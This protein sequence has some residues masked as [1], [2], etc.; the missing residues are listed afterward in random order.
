M[1][2]LPF[3]AAALFAGAAIAQQPPQVG[4]IAPPTPP[5]A[6]PQDVPYP[7]VMRLQVDATDIDRRIFRARQTI[8]VSRAG[9]MTLLYPKW[10]P[11]K[12]GP[13]GAPDKLGGLV[14][15]AHGRPVPWRRDPVESWAYH[16]DVPAGARALD[17]EF[18]F[19]TPT[20]P[21]QGRINV[22][23]E[24][25]NLQWEMVVFYP[26][27]HYASR[28][29][30]QPTLT[31]PQGWGYGAALDPA[32]SSGATT[33]FQPVTLEQL[34]DSPLFAGRHFRQVELDGGALPVRLNI[35]A[36]APENLAIKPE[37]VQLHRNLVIQADR[38][39]GARHFTEYDFLLALTDR[40][41][42]I[43]LE[44]HESSE[45]AVDPNYF[46]EWDKHLGDH[47]LLPHEYVHSWNG[48]FRRGADMWAPNYDVPTRNQFLWVYEGMT[49][50]WGQVLA[51][52]SGLWTRENA[53]GMMAMTAAAYQNRAGR[54]WRALVDTTNDPIILA[55][56][57]QA[58]GNW[59]R[60]E[61]YYNEGLLI[62]LE[63][64]TLIRERS[65][66]RRS[67]DDFARRFFG[68]DSGRA[69][70]KTYDFDEI[71]ATLNA[72]QAY[73]WATFLRTR[74]ENAGGPAPLE[75]FT[76]GGYRL[77]Y[78]E[79]P[80][81]YEKS[82]A[83]GNVSLLYSLGLALNKDAKI[84]SVMW[85]GPA[86]AAGLAVGPTLVAV[87]GLAYTSDRLTKAITAAKGGNQPIELLVKDGDRYRTVPIRYHG[88]LRYPHLERVDGTPGRLDDILKPR[89]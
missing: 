30:V 85:E 70:V 44:H 22:T 18:Q 51:A 3:L 11:G 50:Y 37:Q 88:G 78:R 42:G 84:T 77:V 19:L 1:K 62:W 65:G 81:A 73:D 8:P 2:S 29:M 69:Y 38:L 56:R 32:S 33:T 10:L 46:T 87:N 52:R 49:Q 58:W 80:N 39:F 76:R 28:I 36:D 67:L 47:D 54:Q 75:G 57:P 7:G 55:R 23:P 14:I 82:E 89:A 9:P 16:V 6:A 40:M 17:L 15:T 66:G 12:H 59:Q 25:L 63:A 34:I 60:N 83:G 4:P 48:K 5:I 71:V 41:G 61:D 24:M 26:A 13:R 20:D 64:D 68:G 45:N 79:T 31:L 27:G 74:V 43:G 35:V 72:V 53:L 21:L 86:Y